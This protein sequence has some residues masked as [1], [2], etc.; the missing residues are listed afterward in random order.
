[1]NL[2]LNDAAKSEVSDVCRRSI[3]VDGEAL[4]I[5]VPVFHLKE[6]GLKFNKNGHFNA[7]LIPL[8]A[9]TISILQAV[10]EFVKTQKPTEKYK[11]LWLNKSMFVN[12]S[13]WCKF[14]I[15]KV[16]GT[17]QPLPK[18]AIFGAGLYSVE[19]HVSHLYCGPHKNGETMSLSLFISKI[20]YEPQSNLAEVL[21]STLE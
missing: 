12:I 20:S 6:E 9:K 3:K 21:N 15:V 11:P 19:L 13:K 7:V 5:N 17:V 4:K 2:E 14:E 10:E 1:M 16:D 18:D 8:D